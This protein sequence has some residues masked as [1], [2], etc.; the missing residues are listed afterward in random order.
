MGN[1]PLSKPTI[2]HFLDTYLQPRRVNMSPADGLVSQLYEALTKV[3]HLLIIHCILWPKALVKYIQWITFS[4]SDKGLVADKSGMGQEWICVNQAASHYLNQHWSRPMMQGSFW[5]CTQPMRDDVTLIGWAHTQNDPWWCHMV[6]LDH[7]CLF[8]QSIDMYIIGS[9]CAVR[10][11]ETYEPF[12]KTGKLL[13]K[14][15][16]WWCR[17]LSTCITNHTFTLLKKNTVK[18]LI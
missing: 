15:H 13:T 18:S 14:M 3:W 4:C 17:K 7:C 11:Y 9:L 2:T 16:K 12:A 6:S 5:E 1:K 8:N 10:I